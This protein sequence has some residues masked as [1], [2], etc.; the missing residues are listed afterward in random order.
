MPEEGRYFF[1]LWPDARVRARLLAAAKLA[2]VK[3]RLHHPEDLHM[4]LVFL[5]Q[6]AGSQHRCIDEVAEGIRGKPFNLNIDHTGYWPRPKI[7]WAAPAVTPEPLSQ[8]VSDLRIGLTGCGFEPEQRSYR[9]HVTLYRKAVEAD[10]DGMDPT[11][12][13]AVTDFVLAVSAGG[14]PGSPRYRI[15]RR[16]P[17]ISSL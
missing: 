1:A 13:W 2:V 4:T 15:V 14:P 12:E 17:L 7:L 16:W 3:G 5:G 6:V 9:P 11:I 10:A 8:L